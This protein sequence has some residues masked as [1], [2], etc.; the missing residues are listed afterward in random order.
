M[1][2]E[3]GVMIE[4]TTIFGKTLNLAEESI[5]IVTGPAP[6][7]NGPLAHISGPSAGSIIVK[8]APQLLIARLAN[9]AAFAVFHRPNGTPVWV[10]APSV[11]LIGAPLS[12]EVGL[13]LGTVRAVILGDGF[14]QSVQED[15]NTAEQIVAVHSN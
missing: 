2:S 5:S 3:I 14:H 13:G 8:E 6:S 12:T 1:I 9:P 10:R 15:V 7:E 11:S 4:V